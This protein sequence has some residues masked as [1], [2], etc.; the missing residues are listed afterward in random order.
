MRCASRSA[1]STNPSLAG[2][3]VAKLVGDLKRSEVAD[4]RVT[5]RPLGVGDGDRD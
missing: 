2:L 4:V 5:I 1:R 3:E